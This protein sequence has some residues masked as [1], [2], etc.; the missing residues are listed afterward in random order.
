M[1]ILH[2]LDH[3]IPV[4]DG[5]SVRTLS[6]LRHQRELG[7]E[8]VHVTGPRHEIP[9]PAVERVDGWEFFRTPASAG[10]LGRLPVLQYVTVVGD[11]SRRIGEVARAARPDVIHAHSP[12]LNGLAALRAG[13]RLSIPVVYEVRALWE[14]AA[15]GAGAQSEGGLRYRLSRALESLTL[16]EADAVT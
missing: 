3:S 11:L 10:L 2:V 12:A 15:V 6:I 9:G 7:W 5:Y 8:T 13:R 4:L 16:R 14:D 1:R